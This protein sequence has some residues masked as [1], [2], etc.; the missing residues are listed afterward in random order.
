M[1]QPPAELNEILTKARA[2]IRQRE[3]AFIFDKEFTCGWASLHVHRDGNEISLVWRSKDTDI[4]GYKVLIVVTEIHFSKDPGLCG[5]ELFD[6][7]GDNFINF[8]LQEGSSYHF[9]CVFYEDDDDL[10]YAKTIMFEIGIP[11]SSGHRALLEKA[12]KLDSNPGEKIKHRIETITN[13]TDFLEEAHAAAIERIKN[14]NISAKA[15]KAQIESLNEQ[16]SMLKNEF[17]M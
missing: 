3:I 13:T 14:K 2:G 6:K 16:I 10:K 15:K 17:G 12:L 9:R 7:I 1:D 11:L 5:G 8:V 4:V